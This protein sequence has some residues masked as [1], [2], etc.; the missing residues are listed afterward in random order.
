[1]PAGNGGDDACANCGKTGSDTV[2]L[3]NCTACRL[4]KYC[5]VDC[6]KVHRKQH[7]KA[8]KQRAAELKDEQLYSQGHERP[9]EDFCP[10]CSLP[11]PLP[12]N[13]HSGFN[14][15]C[16]KRICDG[17]DFAVQTRKGACADCPFCRTPYPDNNAD[18]LAMIHARVAKKDPCAISNLAEQYAQGTVGLQND[19]RKAVELWREAAA[20]GSVGSLYNLGISYRNGKGI[21][22]DKTKGL[23]FYNKAAMKGH[24]LSRYNLGGL[25]GQ[26]GNYDRAV[27]HFLISAKMGHTD[28]LEMVK[29]MYIDRRATKEQYADARKGYQEAVEETKSH[30][31]DEAAKDPYGNHP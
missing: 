25:E 28:S 13:E 17:C 10:I 19:V 31:R 8:C 23:Q 5:S 9:E 11:I 24:V 18:A 1:M 6:Q 14:V 20:L 2:K 3:K 26:K 27:R 7:K 22:E 16:M 12:V 21:Q 4:V 30:D 15:C 29:K